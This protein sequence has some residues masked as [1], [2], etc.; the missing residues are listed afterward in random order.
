MHIRLGKKSVLMVA[1]GAAIGLGAVDKASA[2][3]HS[4][5]YEN[6]GPGAVTIWLG[7]YTH[8]GHHLEG[9]M[10]LVGVNGTTFASTTLAFTQLTATGEEFKPD[11]LIDGVT[12][13]YVSTPLGVPGPLVGSQTTWLTSLCPA[14]GPANHW[15][16]VTFSGLAAGDYQF[17]YVPIA[18]PSLEW[19][20]YNPSLNGVF[21]LTGEVVNPEEPPVGAIPEPETYALM[22]AGLGMVAFVARRRKREAA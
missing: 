8:G 1:V 7:T 3:A 22:L 19:D 5:G 9:S 15:Q 4:I 2:H 10:N 20:P 6:A 17:T 18:N 21:T 11:G 12:N 14:C 13:F 16:G